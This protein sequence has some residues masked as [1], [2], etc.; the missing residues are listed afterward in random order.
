M[1]EDVDPFNPERCPACHSPKPHLFPAVQEG[2]EVAVCRHEYH[3]RVTP[4]NTAGRI[5]ERE[6]LFETIEIFGGSRATKITP[7]PIGRPTA[8]PL[9]PAPAPPE[10]KTT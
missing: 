2:S 7:R 5:A 8:I 1:S 10:A 4:Q 3:L 9:S 6:A